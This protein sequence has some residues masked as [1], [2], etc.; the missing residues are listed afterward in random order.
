MLAEADV[1]SAEALRPV[2]SLDRGVSTGARL[3]E[4]ATER[5]NIEH[6]PAI[7]NHAPNVT[8]GGRMKDF[9]GGIAGHLIK[10]ADLAAALRLL[11]ITFRRHHDTQCRIGVPAQIDLAQ[12]AIA[13]GD[14]CR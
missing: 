1:A 9:D 8:A 14:H 2:D 10:T 5:S 3:F 4:I 6:A 12:H 11:G 7:R 13:G